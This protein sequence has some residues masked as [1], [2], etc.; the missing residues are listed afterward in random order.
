VWNIAEVTSVLK[1]PITAVMSGV[2]PEP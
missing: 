2:Q 1:M